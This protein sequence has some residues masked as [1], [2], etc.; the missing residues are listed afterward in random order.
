MYLVIDHHVITIMS[1]TGPSMAPLFNG[2]HRPD[3]PNDRDRVLI[4]MLYPDKGIQ[5]GMVVAYRTPHDPQKIA[6]KRVV[7]LPGDVV[8]PRSKNYPGSQEGVLVPHYHLWVE[9]DNANNNKTLD[10]NCF[11]PISQ[12]LVL[13]KVVAVLRPLRH[14]Q[15]VNWQAWAGCERVTKDAMKLPSDD[16]EADVAIRQRIQKSRGEEEMAVWASR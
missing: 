5:R 10:S 4:N 7:G 8:R 16:D 12:A 1:V 14:I 6:I 2:D 9:G 13:G 15:F 11:G 3:Q